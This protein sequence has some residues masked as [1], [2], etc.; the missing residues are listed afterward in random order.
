MKA[1]MYRVLLC[2]GLMLGGDRVLAHH[3]FAAEF[4]SDKQV[5]MTGTIAKMEW[6]NPH[7]WR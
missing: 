7:A 2:V 1:T 5:T 4:D 3:A 6:V